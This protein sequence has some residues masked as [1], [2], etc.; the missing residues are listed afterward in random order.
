MNNGKWIMD[1][2][3]AVFIIHYPFSVIGLIHLDLC[4]NQAAGG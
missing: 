4:Y 2:E 3:E 1:N